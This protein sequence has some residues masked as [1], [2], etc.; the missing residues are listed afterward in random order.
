MQGHGGPQGRGGQVQNSV[1][2]KTIHCSGPDPRAVQGFLQAA[3]SPVVTGIARPRIAVSRSGHAGSV[4]AESAT[5]VSVTKETPSATDLELPGEETDE[6]PAPFDLGVDRVDAVPRGLPDG[7]AQVVDHPVP[8]LPSEFVKGEEL[9]E[10]RESRGDLHERRGGPVGA[11]RPERRLSARVRGDPDPARLV[12]FHGEAAGRPARRPRHLGRAAEDLGEPL[13]GATERFVDLRPV[14]LRQ[15][16]VP[17]DVVP[18]VDAALV[19]RR[20][21][22]AHPRDGVLAFPDVGRGEERPVEHRPDSVGRR[23]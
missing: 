18:G 16:V 8:P 22:L 3:G 9:V 15:P 17:V 6:R 11:Q 2:F 13:R 12:G 10:G 19:P 7:P 4:P 1:L 14:H 21:R 23:G 5:S 20:G